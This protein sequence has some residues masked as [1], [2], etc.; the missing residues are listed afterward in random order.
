MHVDSEKWCQQLCPD[1]VHS[2]QQ[3]PAD[4]CNS[5][6]KGIILGD[7]FETLHRTASSLSQAA[8]SKVNSCTVT[9]FNCPTDAIIVENHSKCVKGLIK[10]GLHFRNCYEIYFACKAVDQ[11][12][13][14]GFLICDDTSRFRDAF[15]IIDSSLDAL[16]NVEPSTEKNTLEL[17]FISYIMWN[18]DIRRVYLIW[19]CRSMSVCCRTHFIVLD[20]Y[21]DRTSPFLKYRHEM[22]IKKFGPNLLLLLFSSSLSYQYWFIVLVSFK[23]TARDG[24]YFIYT[25]FQ[26][27][28]PNSRYSHYNFFKCCSITEIL[29][30]V[31][32]NEFYMFEIDFD[33]KTHSNIDREIH[34]K[35][36]ENCPHNCVRN[37]INKTETKISF[38]ANK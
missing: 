37:H 15:F 30:I 19:T 34:L 6:P 25:Y 17:K 10:Y 1:S 23:Y 3:Y 2:V 22:S 29:K 36:N 26:Y 27:A 5:R 7:L 21:H 28:L 8:L 14:Q 13:N 9:R 35:A 33:Y 11:H 31:F 32:V 24:K 16:K 4:V 12:K 18:K 38:K 20:S